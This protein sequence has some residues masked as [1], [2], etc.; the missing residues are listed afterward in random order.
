[1][2]MAVGLFLLAP[3][4]IGLV[5]CGTPTATLVISA[6]ATAV[7]GSPFTITVT[8][9]D[10]GR[11]DTIFNSDVKFTSSDSAASLPAIYTFTA[12]DAGSHTFANGVTLMT[13]GTQSITATVTVA[14]SITGRANVVVTTNAGT[15]R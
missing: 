14:S 1:M 3:A 6:P 10:G 11:R 2:V 13:S 7:A 12:A 9:M 15:P 8:A 4:W 5:S